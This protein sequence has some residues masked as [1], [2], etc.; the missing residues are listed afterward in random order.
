M[1]CDLVCRTWIHST[2]CR[3][4]TTLPSLISLSWFSSLRP[5]CSV[6]GLNCF[7]LCFRWSQWSIC[8]LLLTQETCQHWGGTRTP[9]PV[10]FSFFSFLAPYFSHFVFVQVCVVL[11]GHGAEGLWLQDG[12]ACGSCWRW[13]T[14]KTIVHLLMSQRVSLLV[15]LM[16]VCV[17]GHAEVVRFLLEACKVNPVPKDR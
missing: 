14:N 6:L 3:R 13:N 15:E 9:H 10:C 17:S 1:L 11:Y 16:C 2:T 5:V 8:C 7:L 4:I 12:A